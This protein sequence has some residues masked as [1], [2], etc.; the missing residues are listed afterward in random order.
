M[1]FA[2]QIMT[3][4]RANS[5]SVLAVNAVS[6]NIMILIPWQFCSFLQKATK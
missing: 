5:W 3:V 4:G 1:Q 2:P 6:V